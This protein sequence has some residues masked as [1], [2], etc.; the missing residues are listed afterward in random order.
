M[1]ETSTEPPRQTARQRRIEAQRARIEAVHRQQRRRRAIW[2]TL[3]L[4]AFAL[5]VA[6]ALLLLKPPSIAQGRQVLSEGASHAVTGGPL[7][8]RNRPPSSGPHYDEPAAYGVVGEGVGP[9]NWVH[10]LEHGGVVVLYRPDLCDQGC[11]GELQDVYNRAPRSSRFG[12][13]KLVVTPY[14]D[15]D[16]A[17]AIVAWNWVDE[18]D[19]VDRD[20]LLAFYREHVDRGPEAAS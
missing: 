13:V 15:M 3:I 7:A 6:L 17:V 9:G 19:G 2:G 10:T 4:V 5:L 1:G 14:R 11:V 18:M 12:N 16:R 8:Y 20:R